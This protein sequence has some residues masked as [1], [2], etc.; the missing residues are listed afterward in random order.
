ME[1]KI[2]ILFQQP[3]VQSFISENPQT[4]RWLESQESSNRYLLM[5]VIAAGQGAAVFDGFDPETLSGVDPF[6]S[7]LRDLER[8]YDA[9]GGILGYQATVL[10]LLES[11]D[12]AGKIPENT[13][14]RKPEGMDLERENLEVRQMVRFGIESLPKLAQVFVVG[15]AGDRL[16]LVCDVEDEPLPAA[17]L[18]MCGKTLLEG[19]IRD[20]QALEYLYYK[21]HGRQ[22]V[23][24]LA[25]MTSHE[26]HNHYRILKLLEENDWFQ[27]PRESIRLFTQPLVPMVDERGGWIV[28]KPL[29]PMLKPGGHGAIWKLAMDQ[30]IFDWFEGAGKEKGLVRQINNPVAGTDYGLL[31]FLGAGFS[32]DKDFGFAACPRLPNAAEGTDI[33]I[34][35]V[36]ENGYRYSISNIE[37]TE[38]ERRGIKDEPV[39]DDYPYSCFPANTNILFFDFDA[40][41][42]AQ[43]R[44]PIPGMLMN[45]KNSVECKGR[46]LIA[47]R[48]ESTMQNIA[49]AIDNV[50]PEP[51]DSCDSLRSYI[52]F[53]KR[54]KTLSVAKNAFDPDKSVNGTP[55]GCLYE[56][57]ENMRELFVDRCGMVLP[58]LGDKK[59][60]LEEGPGFLIFFH[61]G[62]GPLY[63]VVAEKVRG[64]SMA[65]GSDMVL[66]IAELEM[67]NLE[68]EGSLLIEAEAVLG[69]AEKGVLTYSEQTGRCRLK[70]VVVKNKGIDRSSS[71]N[72][73]WKNALVRQET[74]EIRLQGCSE[75][76]AEGVTFE[77]NQHLVVP[78]GKRMTAYEEGGELKFRL[79]ALEKPL[80]WSYSYGE[81]DSLELSK[82]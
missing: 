38:F 82:I 65:S 73:F 29:H 46:E 23:I 28:D 64:G 77:G 62:L 61:P 37:Y 76:V 26:K 42:E 19:L 43:S 25:L 10:K 80:G 3:H 74:L 15:G 55:Q 39:S 20:V 11:R 50:F 75:F 33:L 69:H 41:R 21:L 78:D 70:N 30:G 66:E 2:E 79:E 81:N 40:I 1:K 31:A 17:Q 51:I 56:M 59:K 35:Q 14:Y 16:S 12:S 5:L 32:G 47:G 4:A 54:R 18:H 44:C 53:N 22:V 60:Y 71:E 36:V 6:L 8:F 34:E 27:R 9:I 63:S 52:T 24:P 57:M 67:E 72:I 7:T 45:M 48:L 13:T 58:D 49:D 68:L